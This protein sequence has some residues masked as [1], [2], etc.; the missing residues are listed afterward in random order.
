MSKRTTTPSLCAC[1]VAEKLT[2]SHRL[3]LHS[4]A[5]SRLEISV[6]LN[7]ATL[8]AGRSFLGIFSRASVRL[9]LGKM[10]AAAASG[11]A[12]L[13]Y[14]QQGLA[15]RSHPHMVVTIGLGDCMC[16]VL[17]ASIAPT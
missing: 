1:R 13:L 15:G 8:D 11:P 14:A 7:E 9:G 10:H 17:L 12:C 6:W 2:R 3:A 4:L 16:P 5:A